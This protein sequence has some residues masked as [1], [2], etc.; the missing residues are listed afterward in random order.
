VR[1]SEALPCICTAL[2]GS[3]PIKGGTH[4]RVPAEQTAAT[5]GNRGIAPSRA[6]KVATAGFPA[7]F[8]VAADPRHPKLTDY[9]RAPHAYTDASAYRAFYGISAEDFPA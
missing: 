2:G 1:L 3:C 4:V 9:T 7:H 5:P 8:R 6:T